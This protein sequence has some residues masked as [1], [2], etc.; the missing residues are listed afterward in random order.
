MLVAGFRAGGALTP[1]SGWS[2]CSNIDFGG[3]QYR[4]VSVT[5]SGTAV[6]G[7]VTNNGVIGDALQG[8]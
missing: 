7:G 2:L 1:D 8:P 5:Q 3:A 6:T 4:Q